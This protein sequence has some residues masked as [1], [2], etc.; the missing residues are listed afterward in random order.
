MFHLHKR[1]LFQDFPE[2][3]KLVFV[4]VL[5]GSPYNAK[6]D[7]FSFGIV[8]YQIFC[9][10]NIASR[11]QTE[12]EVLDFAKSVARGR[13]LAMPKRFPPQLVALVEE[14][15]ADDPRLRPTAA[16]CLAAL[17]RMRAQMDSDSTVGASVGAFLP[18]AC[19]CRK[20][21]LVAE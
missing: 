5:R 18:G 11:F 16:K 17:Q 3:Q 4:Q 2:L 8:A 1:V 15:W 6:V 19:L 10:Q 21:A 20:P 7:M 9:K 13:R 14:L 12:E